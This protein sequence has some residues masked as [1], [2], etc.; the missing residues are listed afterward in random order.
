MNLLENLQL[1]DIETVAVDIDGDGLVADQHF[2]AGMNTG[3]E[4]FNAEWLFQV[5]VQIQGPVAN[6]GGVTI[7]SFAALNRDAAY[8]R[9]L[10]L[11]LDS[12]GDCRACRE[13]VAAVARDRLPARRTSGLHT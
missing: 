12:D 10:P 3:R 7:T 1:Y 5:P 4:R 9:N 8:G 13:A 6:I 11:R 2:V